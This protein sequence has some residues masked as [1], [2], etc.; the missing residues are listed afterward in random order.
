MLLNLDLVFVH[1]TERCVLDS[2]T[3]DN[4][5]KAAV[6]ANH[7]QRR[8]LLSLVEKERSLSELSG[9]TDTP[10]SLLHHHISKL[11]RLGLVAIA[12]EEARA[13]SP[14]KYYRATAESFFVPAHLMVTLPGE[15]MQQRLR[16]LLDRGLTH[17]IQGVRFGVENGRPR[18]FL[19]RSPTPGRTSLELWLDL[20]LSRADAKALAGELQALMQKFEARAAEQGSRYIVHTAL[21]HY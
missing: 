12:H 11:M 4:P 19:V 10:L 14:I 3:I 13:G 8:I 7:R 5:A 21:A 9:L 20:R 18:M 16:E 1:L 6:L 17:A 2:V 15:G